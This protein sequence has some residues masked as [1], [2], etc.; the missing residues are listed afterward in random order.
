VVPQDPGSKAVI[1]TTHYRAVVL[2]LST[3]DSGF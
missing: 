1:G 3:V 2:T